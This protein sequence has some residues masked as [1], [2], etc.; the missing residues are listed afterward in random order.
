MVGEILGEPS[1]SVPSGRG[2]CNATQILR[3]RMPYSPNC[4]GH[5]LRSPKSASVHWPRGKRAGFGPGCG[6]L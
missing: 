1:T 6:P 5:S 4:F 3:T 2:E